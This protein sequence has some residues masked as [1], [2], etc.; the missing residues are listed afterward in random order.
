VAASDTNDA[1]TNDEASNALD[2]SNDSLALDDD[3]GFDSP[4]L[5]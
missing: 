2:D 3:G 4:D 5:G 1:L